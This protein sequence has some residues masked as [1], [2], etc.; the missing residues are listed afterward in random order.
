MTRGASWSAMVS[1]ISA[2]KDKRVRVDCKSLRRGPGK[3]EKSHQQSQT[4]PACW[5]RTRRS[6]V[7][8]S[9]RPPTMPRK[10]KAIPGPSRLSKI[11]AELSADPR[12][13]L[14]DVKSLKL[15]LAFRND[16]FGAR[17]AL[18]SSLRGS[19]K[20]LCCARRH[21]VKED[22]PRIRYVNPT[23]DIQVNKIPKTPEEVWQPEMAI[24]FREC[25]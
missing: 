13:Q 16:H 20:L 25:T 1:S 22:L 24:E 17:C 9:A 2:R 12:P 18:R 10:P 21:F 15:T 7:D 19:A 4:R 3:S 11:L 14:F 6:R 23:V 8:R 5:P